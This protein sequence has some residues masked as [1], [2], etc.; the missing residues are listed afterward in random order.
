MS[1]KILFT[2]LIC[3]LLGTQSLAQLDN[4][5]RLRGEGERLYAKSKYNQANE[6]YEQAYLLSLKYDQIDIAANLL[7]DM[8]SVEI[9]S[10][11]YRKSIALCLNGL[12]LL[13]KYPAK[14]DSTY[15]K[16]LSSLGGHYQQLNQYDSSAYYFTKADER[17]SQ[18]PE[19]AKDIPD[20]VMYH[21]SNQALLHEDMGR[22]SFS[23]NLAQ[24]A[25]NMARHRRLLS[26][27]SILS[28]VLAGQ[29]ERLGNYSVAMALR[30][31]GLISNRAW[32][33]QRARILSGIG[34]NAYLQKRYTEACKYLNM[35]RNLYNKLA[36]KDSSQADI[37][38]LA[39]LY[40][41]LGECYTS[42][43]QFGLAEKWV[44]QA[45]N[46]YVKKYGPFGKTLS[47]S[48]L[49][50][51]KLMLE[52]KQIAKALVYNARALQAVLKTK[53][54]TEPNPNLIPADVLDEKAAIAAMLYEGNIYSLSN[55]WSKALTAYQFGITVF[56]QAQTRMN[57]L[58]DRLYANESVAPLYTHG[59]EAAL[60]LYQQS[61]TQAA[62]NTAFE[63]IDQSRAITLQIVMSEK[64]IQPQYIPSIQRQREQRLRQD[65]ASIYSE[66][67]DKPTVSKQQY[68]NDKETSIKLEH[69]RLLEDWKRKYP[70]YYQIRYGLQPVQ[71]KQ[72]QA[73][74][75]DD[76][77]YLTYNFQ[78][79]RLHIFAITRTK[80][81]WKTVLVDSTILFRTIHL[82]ESTIRV[83]PGLRKYQGTPFSLLCFDWFF[84]P[85]EALIGSKN[86]WIINA[87]NDFEHVPFEV[88]E[89]GRSVNDYVS[90]RHSIQ[91]IYSGT[92][93]LS[94]S[95]KEPLPL[96]SILGVA[97]FNRPVDSLI[98]LR[99]H[100]STL[101]GSQEEVNTI[102]ATWLSGSQATRAN[103]LQNATRYPV[104]YLDTHA[105]LN[106]T[107]PMQSYIAFFPN[108]TSFSHR[109]HAEEISQMN[110]LQTK[111]I[112]LSACESGSGRTY[113]LEGMMSIA[114][115]LAIAGCPSI[116]SPLWNVH[117][118]TSAY[119]I[120][121]IHLHLEEGYPPATAI[122]KAR[123]DFFTATQN[124]LYNHP[125]FW[126]NYRLIGLNNA[127]KKKLFL[128]NLT[129][130]SSATVLLCTAALLTLTL[131]Y[132]HFRT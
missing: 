14:K 18:H 26:D 99:F 2:I 97:P 69:Y 37:R 24:K 77:A 11:N 61:R 15:F 51:S 110:L 68:L 112:V 70:G 81:L 119:L 125:F 95:N 88:L 6:Y 17:L 12:T 9:L 20:Y 34:R 105:Y 122:H 59:I 40:N 82:L 53:K 67:F 126:A 91:Y 5:Y 124:R 31:E 29:Y 21:Y 90:L 78:Y 57:L 100:Y 80:T 108:D 85:V 55:N 8:S 98:N 83:H 63:L 10:G 39:N 32:D 75:T 121:Q 62:Y 116:I 92:S 54:T 13:T 118:R 19:I 58:H 71:I 104:W 65:L 115:T 129:V 7:V 42:L 114:R 36:S 56:Q 49:L 43:H 50:L 76:Q 132:Y 93:L 74:L 1:N 89:T 22:Y 127:P 48:W 16:L 107:K 66:W 86:D 117:D 102:K 27:I 25:L 131:L 72:I 128:T 46:I 111:L 123:N 33:L 87:G 30:K 106:L 52:K 23:M 103:F 28:N 84:K 35:S 4:I 94:A 44:N 109:L 45:I 79:G 60:K 73:V 47:T 3:H 38:T 101:A 96:N 41:H 120:K 130:H 113:P 64:I